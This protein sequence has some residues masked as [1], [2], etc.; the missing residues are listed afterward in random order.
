MDEG[1]QYCTS[2]LKIQYQEQYI[3]SMNLSSS[4]SNGSPYT[5]GVYGIFPLS[6]SR[7]F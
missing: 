7:P 3:T 6:A 4:S 5:V 2:V 1:S